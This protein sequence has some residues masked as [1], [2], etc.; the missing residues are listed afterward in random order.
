[1]TCIRSRDDCGRMS[2]HHTAPAAPRIRVA[3]DSDAG[4]LI[5]LIGSVY[6]E[7]PGCI[8]DVDR[9]EPDLRAIFSA[10]AAK[11]GQFWVAVDGADEQVVGCIGWSPSSDR[12]R[13]GWLELRKLYVA[14]SH[15]R[16]GLAGVLCEFVEAAARARSAP[17]IELWSD[18][19]FEAAHRFYAQRRYERQ[20][21]A[22]QLF[23]LSQSSEYHFVLRLDG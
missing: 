1:M 16:R 10:Y 8:L 19:R 9:E 22:R 12:S 14:R 11:G 6:A 2:G 5:A 7:Y 4:A 21:G 17:G 3:R 13:P 18:T 20:S 23:D 15:R